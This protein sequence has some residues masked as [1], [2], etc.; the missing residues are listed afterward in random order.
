MRIFLSD[1]AQGDLDDAW[2]QLLRESGSRAADDRLYDDFDR[3]FELIVAHP[4]MGR[5][6]NELQV[7]V[8]S[9]AHQAYIIFYRVRQ[10][11]V[12]VLRVLHQRRDVDEAFASD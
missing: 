6:R 12:D 11:E 7:G 10:D 2:D 4:E 8:R 5:P 9:F 1:E 3:L